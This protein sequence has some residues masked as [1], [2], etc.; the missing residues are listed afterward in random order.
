MK[1]KG[2]KLIILV[3]LAFAL[4]T[5][6]I[7]YLVSG[8]HLKSYSIADATSLRWMLLIILLS[9]GFN[10]IITGYKHIKAEK[11]LV[12]IKP[13]KWKLFSWQPFPNSLFVLNFKYR[14]ALVTTGLLFLGV[15]V[16]GMGNAWP[17]QILHYLFTFLAAVM[18]FITVTHSLTG[19]Q[20]KLITIFLWGSVAVWLMGVLHI[21]FS[22]YLG[23]LLFTLGASYWFL[24][25]VVKNEVE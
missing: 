2:T 17:I 25:S 18:T 21:V 22:I 6:A 23:E 10:F 13:R 15:A 16:F 9:I 3:L 5:I 12:S 14:Q 7:M 8:G 1:I 4:G 24:R 11:H 19:L 20:R